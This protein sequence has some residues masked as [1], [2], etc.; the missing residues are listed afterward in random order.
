VIADP[1]ER[2]RALAAFHRTVSASLFDQLGESGVLPEGDVERSHA[3]E[4]WEIFTLYA[5]VRGLVAASGFGD[6][7]SKAIDAFHEAA[8]E[9]RWTRSG[10]ARA[11]ETWRDRVRERYEA[12]G[13]LS[14]EGGKAG[15]ADLTARLGAAAAAHMAGTAASPELAQMAGALHESMAEGAAAWLQRGE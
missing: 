2:G 8:L 5:C 7:T 14:R 10:D 3:R 12:Y 13:A 15:A 11:F 6:A 1:E 9:S 4:E